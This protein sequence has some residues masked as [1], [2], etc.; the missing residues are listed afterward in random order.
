[1]FNFSGAP[2]NGVTETLKLLSGIGGGTGGGAVV[3]VGG[4]GGGA[5][6]GEGALGGAEGVGVGV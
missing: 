2:S 6:V 1:M 4:L 3:G 5:V